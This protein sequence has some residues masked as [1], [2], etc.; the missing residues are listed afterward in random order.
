M[1]NKQLDAY[2]VNG[3][4]QHYVNGIL[5]PIRNTRETKT[6]QALLHKFQIRTS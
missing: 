1:V 2:S 5:S 6:V 3:G 4:K